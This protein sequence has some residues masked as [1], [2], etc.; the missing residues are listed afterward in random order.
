M[1]RFIIIFSAV[2]LTVFIGCSGTK[3]TKFEKPKTI[4]FIKKGVKLPAYKDIK[5]PKKDLDIS[6]SDNPEV[7]AEVL[8]K[9]TN[10]VY[11]ELKCPEKSA[12]VCGK[13]PVYVSGTSGFYRLEQLE[14]M[15]SKGSGIREGFMLVNPEEEEYFISTRDWFANPGRVTEVK[16]SKNS[17]LTA[18][19]MI[20][21]TDYKTQILGELLIVEKLAKENPES[22][23]KVRTDA[24]IKKYA[25]LSSKKPGSSARI[26][27]LEGE[28]LEKIRSTYEKLEKSAVSGF[29][30]RAQSYKSL[31]EQFNKLSKTPYLSEK[32]F[33]E[34]LRDAVLAPQAGNGYITSASDVSAVLKKA[35]DLGENT[36]GSEFL[37]NWKVS[38]EPLKGVKISADKL[39][40]S[41]ASLGTEETALES[42]SAFADGDKFA[43]KLKIAGGEFSVITKET[44]P[45]LLEGGPGLKE[46]IKQ[47]NGRYGELLWN[48]EFG[49]GV[50]KSVLKDIPKGGYNP[51]TGMMEYSL[52]TGENVHYW[53]MLEIIRRSPKFGAQKKDYAGKLDD[54]NAEFISWRQPK[55]E[56]LLK[57][58]MYPRSES[59]ETE[60]ITCMKD[61][62]SE[63]LKISFLPSELKSENPRLIFAF[64]SGNSVC[65]SFIS[66]ALNNESR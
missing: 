51:D 1:T 49:P 56:F 9:K 19:A 16:L 63:K 53:I 59:K 28:V 12:A 2:L 65:D 23:D 62:G 35:K 18:I 21:S 10:A 40:S 52:D 47:I 24:I 15:I 6:E 26:T 8:V 7:T 54:P 33:A 4:F 14:E 37:V 43:L 48:N 17:M 57:K 5:N 38:I 60:E 27:G 46:Y 41:G 42:V 22:E 13:D 55:G 11:Y 39:D 45:Y 66:S 50:V 25:V 64:E 34:I 3:V 32:I 29:P 30:M 58:Y 36:E 20:E 31:A 44:G 61:K